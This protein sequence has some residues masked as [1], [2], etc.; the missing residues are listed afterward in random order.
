MLLAVVVLGCDPTEPDT[1]SGDSGDITDVGFDDTPS[2][3]AADDEDTGDEAEDAALS[4]Y[5]TCQDYI[6]LLDL[7]YE[8]SGYYSLEDFGI[9]PDTY[10]TPYEDASDADLY[11][12]WSCFVDVLDASDCTTSE[13]V[14]Q[15]SRGMRGC[16]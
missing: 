11:E 3:D 14:G 5:E 4:L 10:C 12:L 6:D 16:Y 9:D 1:K 8:E 15:A 7:C 2:E 13:G